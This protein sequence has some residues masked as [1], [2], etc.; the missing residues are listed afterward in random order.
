MLGNQADQ[1][2]DQKSEM[3]FEP[4]QLWQGEGRRCKSRFPL[5]IYSRL[6]F[7]ELLSGEVWTVFSRMPATTAPCTD[8]GTYVSVGFYLWSECSDHFVEREVRAPF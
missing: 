1:W 7:Q 3:G 4:V 8:M 6:R 2:P 5:Q